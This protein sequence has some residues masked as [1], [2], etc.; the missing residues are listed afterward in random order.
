LQMSSESTNLSKTKGLK[1]QARQ[2]VSLDIIIII[3][4]I[5]QVSLDL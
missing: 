5:G 2:T 3:H 1:S 4:W